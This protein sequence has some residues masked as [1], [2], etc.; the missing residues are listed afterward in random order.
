MKN[1]GVVEVS[2]V[3]SLGSVV[4]IRTVEAK[5][6]SNQFDWRPVGLPTGVYLLS[7]NCREVRRAVKLVI[8]E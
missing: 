6:G 2:I 7:L 3:N 1:P 5:A 8:A 4:M